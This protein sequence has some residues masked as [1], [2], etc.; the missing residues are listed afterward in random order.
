MLPSPGPGGRRLVWLLPQSTPPPPAHLLC[1]PQARLPK[2]W[3][4]LRGCGRFT[5]MKHAFL[6]DPGLTHP[7][8]LAA[9][10][11]AGRNT[12]FWRDFCPWS[13]VP[14]G[15]SAGLLRLDLV[16]GS[17]SCRVEGSP[18]SVCLTWDSLSPSSRVAEPSSDGQLM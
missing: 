14:G 15:L 6:W 10:W 12:F 2:S 1:I 11:K 16:A 5:F 9:L 17:R 18:G 13:S 3:P 7:H 4:T 8:P